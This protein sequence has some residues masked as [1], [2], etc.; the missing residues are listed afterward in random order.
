V[1]VSPLA[2]APRV[3]LNRY[4][5]VLAPASSVRDAVVPPPETD[6]DCL[7][8]RV[9]AGGQDLLEGFVVL[10]GYDIGDA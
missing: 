1:A 10:S 7:H 8:F 4:S 3:N 5:G 2:P 9:G 6:G